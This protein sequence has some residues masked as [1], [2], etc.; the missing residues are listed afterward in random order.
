MH[1][2]PH[3]TEDDYVEFSIPDALFKVLTVHT[4]VVEQSV[5]VTVY[6]A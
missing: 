2:V 6:M 5:C 4:R 1:A 3:A